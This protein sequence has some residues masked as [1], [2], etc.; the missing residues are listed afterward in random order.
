MNIDN[1]YVTHEERENSGEITS[2]TLVQSLLPEDNTRLSIEAISW[3]PQSIPRNIEATV[4]II[5]TDAVASRIGSEVLVTSGDSTVHID[6]NTAQAISD[7]MQFESD[8]GELLV[9]EADL[10]WPLRTPDFGVAT[11]TI[12]IV[13]YKTPEGT[14][15]KA[16]ADSEEAI[17]LFNKHSMDGPVMRAISSDG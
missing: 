12:F 4:Q 5:L 6:I 11:N 2:S 13:S 16:V 8:R 1:G 15:K 3:S 10:A 9:G 7:A 14:Y 17:E